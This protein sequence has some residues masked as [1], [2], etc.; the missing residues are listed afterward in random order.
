VSSSA[1]TGPVRKGRV[2]AIRHAT[3]A[4]VGD[5]LELWRRAEAHPSATDTSHDLGRVVD[6]PHAAVLVAAAG[7]GAI[8]GSLIATFDG[9]R[10][11][12]YRM[13]VDPKERRR[14][15]ARRLAAAAEDWLRASGAVRLSALVEGDNATAQAFWEAVGFEHYEGM[16]RYS[17]NL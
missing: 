6:A 16:R 13:A 4:D 7:D 5:I 8:V 12:L 10:G 11:N 3:A 1:P 9:W 14:G 17:K 2:L 15:L